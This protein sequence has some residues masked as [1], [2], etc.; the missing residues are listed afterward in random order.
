MGHNTGRTLQAGPAADGAV[1]CPPANLSV[2]GPL[3]VH[4]APAI[5]TGQQQASI[6]CHV[7]PGTLDH[8]TATGR[9]PGTRGYLTVTNAD[10][11]DSSNMRGGESLP[12]AATLKRCCLQVSA[13]TVCERVGVVQARPDQPKLVRGLAAAH[14]GSPRPASC[15]PG[16]K[17]PVVGGKLHFCH[18]LAT[19]DGR[20]VNHSVSVHPAKS[21][22]SNIHK[23]QKNV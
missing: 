18:L 23:V 21:T 19:A 8:P 5:C 16:C 20:G 13:P 15:V 14:W 12:D 11:H 1:S 4:V 2:G 10:Q 9:G 17:R 7:V 3:S 6:W 22:H